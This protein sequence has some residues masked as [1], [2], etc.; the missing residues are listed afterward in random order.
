[1][2]TGYY[3]PPRPYLHSMP[4]TM[5]VERDTMI[6][7][8]DLFSACL[9]P[10][11][12]SEQGG[13]PQYYCYYATQCKYQAGMKAGAEKKDFDSWVKWN[14]AM[15]KLYPASIIDLPEKVADVNGKEHAQGYYK[16]TDAH[17]TRP[18]MDTCLAALQLMVYYR[19]LP[20]TSTKAGAEERDMAGDDA[21][22]PFSNAKDVVVVVEDMI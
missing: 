4:H 9:D 19:Y 15:R 17:S 6:S 16:N 10:V 3:S 2:T 11:V 8:G 18:Y 12:G 20:T 14:L 22:K 1:M 13:S 21:G 7:R 5:V